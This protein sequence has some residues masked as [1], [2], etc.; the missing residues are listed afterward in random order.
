MVWT[1]KHIYL[2][3]LITKWD[4]VSPSR[5]EYEQQMN[6]NKEDTTCYI[7]DKYSHHISL[8]GAPQRRAVGVCPGD[9]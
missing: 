6:M 1:M 3:L 8:A 4:Q 7:A 9:F 5:Y 2:Y